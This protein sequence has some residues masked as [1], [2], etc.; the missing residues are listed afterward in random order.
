MRRVEP[1]SPE[2][3]PCIRSVWFVA[4][5]T[6]DHLAGYE[7]RIRSA[8]MEGPRFGEQTDLIK[9]SGAAFDGGL[10]SWWLPLTRALNGDTPALDILFQAAREYGTHVTLARPAGRLNDPAG[11]VR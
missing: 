7:L 8:P 9:S 3:A 1:H 6:S 4:D 10:R 2:I 5:N 11:T